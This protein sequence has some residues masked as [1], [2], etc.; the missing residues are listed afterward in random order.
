MLKNPI[1]NAIK[2]PIKANAGPGPNDVVS[3][4]V[5]VTS[6]GEKVTSNP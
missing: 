6:N 2:A 4:A 1:K 5:Q 3:I